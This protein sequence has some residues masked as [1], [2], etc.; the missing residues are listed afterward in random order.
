M[1]TR[2][3]FTRLVVTW[4]VYY[5]RPLTSI[6]QTVAPLTIVGN[7]SLLAISTLTSEVNF[8]TRSHPPCLHPVYTID[9][10]YIVV[11]IWYTWTGLFEWR[12]DP[13]TSQCF[14]SLAWFWHAINVEK[15]AR[16]SIVSIFYTWFRGKRVNHPSFSPFFHV[17]DTILTHLLQVAIRGPSYSPEDDYAGNWRR[18]VLVTQFRGI[19][20]HTVYVRECRGQGVFANFKKLSALSELPDMNPFSCRTGLTSWYQNYLGWLLIHFNKPL[21]HVI[22]M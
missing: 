17:F 20:L 11:I 14:P 4:S 5:R 13:P 10:T 12:T 7:T 9:R 8:Y 19:L 21:D 22:W 1:S 2:D 6:T 3:F 16:R 15:R 18:S